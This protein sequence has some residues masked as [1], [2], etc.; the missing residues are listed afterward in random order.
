[1]NNSGNNQFGLS[2]RSMVTLFSIFK[3]YPDITEVYIFG[4]R[5]LGT[6]KIGSDIDLVVMNNG[7]QPK[8]IS[9]VLADCS[10]SSLPVS[11]DLIDFNAL[12]NADLI[13]HIKRVG[14]LFYR[15]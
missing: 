7:L 1:M 12:S 11:V 4:S 3:R 9:N 10:E 15:S 2:E 14:V 8:S 13:G 5:A 6:Y